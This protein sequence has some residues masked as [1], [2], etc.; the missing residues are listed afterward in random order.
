MRIVCIDDEP[1]AV[2]DTTAICMSILEDASVKG[3]T[4]A[5]EA[6]KWIASN[7]VDV[8][9]L[10]IDMPNINGISLAARIKQI[11]PDTVILFLTAYKEYAFDAFQVHSNGYLLKPVMPDMLKKELDYAMSVK[12]HKAITVI[13][14]CTF[15]NFELMINGEPV[16]FKRSKSKELLAYLIDRRGLSVTRAEASAVLF[17]DQPYDY[18]QQK[19]LDVIIRS[20]R[21]TLRE[22]GVSDIMQMERKGLRIIPYKIQCDMYRFYK[23]DPEAV[24]AFRGEYLE[25]Y[26][27]ASLIEANMRSIWEKYNS[28]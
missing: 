9:L 28:K 20:L 16:R 2:E 23:G 19:Y 4:D 6:L 8:T 27:W 22:Y 5:Y 15:G 21:D 13:E 14:A 12:A 24:K 3:F 18:K 10:D 26:E 11:K 17:E 1:L 7:P 25:S